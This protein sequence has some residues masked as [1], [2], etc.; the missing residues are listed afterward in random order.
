M[1]PLNHTDLAA[2]LTNGENSGVE[3]KRDA[4]SPESLAK[5]LVA[6]GNF[7]GGVV[8]LGV[9]DDG[10]VSG[11]RYSPE[12]TGRKIEEWVMNVCRQNVRPSIIPFFQIL[13]D[14]VPDCDVAVIQ[15]GRGWGCYRTATA[16]LHPYRLRQRRNDYAGVGAAFSAAWASTGRGATGE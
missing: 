8:L 1:R 5:E 15:I 13:P 12:R 3:F 9:E 14:V 2:L 7:E 10:T 6:L 4:V 11:L 16:I